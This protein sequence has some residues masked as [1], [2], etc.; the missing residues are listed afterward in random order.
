MTHLINNGAIISINHVPISILEDKSN[1]NCL[2][3]V[4]LPYCTLGT[5]TTQDSKGTIGRSS[6]AYDT[7][8][9]HFIEKLRT[10][11]ESCLCAF[12]STKPR[13]TLTFLPSIFQNMLLT[14]SGSNRSTYQDNGS[15]IKKSWEHERYESQL[16]GYRMF[17]L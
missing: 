14:T 17:G 4:I 15:C 1:L 2:M 3:Y 7:N 8:V 16:L 12:T 5:A 9:L 11:S 6:D 13:S 10:R